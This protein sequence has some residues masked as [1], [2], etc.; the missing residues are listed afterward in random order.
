[1]AGG[2][3]TRVRRGEIGGGGRVGTGV[4]A[5]A[6]GQNG[7]DLLEHARPNLNLLVVVTES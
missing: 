2:R 7:V 3:E 4:G 6:A 5:R 1:M